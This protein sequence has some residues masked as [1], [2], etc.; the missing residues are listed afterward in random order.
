LDY[1][2]DFMAM[3]E[4]IDEYGGAG[5]LTYF[6]NM[7][8]KELMTKGFDMDKASADETKEANKMVRVKLHATHMLN[9]ANCE[10]YGKLKRSTAENYVSGT[11]KYPVSPDIVLRI[12]N[13]YIPPMGWNSCIKQDSGSPAEEG[14]MFTQSD[15]GDNSW[16]ANMTC[17]GCGIRGHLKRECPN[18]KDKGQDQIHANVKE[19]ENP[20]NGENLFV[21]QK[22]KGMVNKH[23][24]PLDNQSTVHQISNPSLLKNIRKSSKQINIHCNARVSKTELKGEL[25]QLPVH[26]NL[27]SIANVLSLKAVAEK[28]RITYDNWDQNR[29][30][31]V[32]TPNRVVE[33]KWSEHGLHYVDMSLDRD[34]IQHIFVTADMPEE[35]DDKEVDFLHQRVRDDQHSAGKS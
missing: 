25:G 20:D 33:F 3:V 12:L 26:N 9:G 30:F 28:H 15:D 29:V 19:E 16:K 10:K 22:L 24:L 4:V 18:R 8:K 23:Y 21:Q 5:L 2:E 7:I 11:S 6:P 31:K 17:H 13:A 34:I 27:N 14:V 32:H 35:E 1:Q